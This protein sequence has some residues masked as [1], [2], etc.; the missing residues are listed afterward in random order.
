MRFSLPFGQRAERELEDEFRFHMEQEIQ[1][2]IAAGMSVEEARR[3]ARIEFGGI[4]S[5]K[6]EC[7]E[8]RLGYWLETTLSDLSYGLKLLRKSPGFTVVAIALLALGIG[9]N[10]A[11]FSAVNAVLLARWPFPHPEK[12]VVIAEGAPPK[13]G[14]SLV[15]VP[16]YEDYARENKT[17]DQI[18]L[19][20]GQSVNLT[21]QERPD[22]LIGAFVSTNFFE[23]F[24]TRAY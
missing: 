24:G 5:T 10:T 13:P 20:I 14:W 17:F 2:N 3:H 16:N 11:I 18:A 1:K 4:E 22:R 21:G 9:A 7:R 15:S 23:M 19:W 6:E 12:I 8:L